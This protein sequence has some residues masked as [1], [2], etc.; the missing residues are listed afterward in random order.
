MRR[1]A[2][3]SQKWRLDRLLQR[4]GRARASRSS[5]SSTETSRPPY[6]SIPSTTKFSLLN[7]HPN[8]FVQ[9]SPNQ[10][11]KNQFFF[12]HH[13]KICVVDHD[14]AFVGGVDLC[15]G[16]WD[17]PQHRLYDDKPT[18]F[19]PDEQPKDADN[20]QLW[21]GKDYSNPPGPGLLQPA[22]AI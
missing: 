12:A 21:P 15:F 16:R 5:S 18:G 22:R 6:P 13:E 14:M 7:L 20:C 10:F 8:I 4:K 3:I 9:R 1:P 2:C 11:K 17:S 19:E